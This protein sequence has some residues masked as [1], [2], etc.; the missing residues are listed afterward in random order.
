[1]FQQKKKIKGSKK[2]TF[3]ISNHFA[4]F[5]GYQ[6]H[7]FSSHSAPEDSR[8]KETITFPP[9]STHLLTVYKR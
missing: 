6:M 2:N 5:W 1:M 7:W 9:T 3:A 8:K 4:V